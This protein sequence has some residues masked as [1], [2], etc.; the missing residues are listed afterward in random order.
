MD[1]RQ[2]PTALLGPQVLPAVIKE[3]RATC[4]WST[5]ISIYSDLRSTWKILVSAPSTRYIDYVH[6]V[7]EELVEL[8]PRPCVSPYI[9]TVV[10]A[11]TVI[12]TLCR[13]RALLTGGRKARHQARNLLHNLPP[14]L[15]SAFEQK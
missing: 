15:I 5:E 6:L 13:I 14:R 9:S 3:L 2:F 1:T 4:G 11:L 7:Q 12:L 10:T 8:L